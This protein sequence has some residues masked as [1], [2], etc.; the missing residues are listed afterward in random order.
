MPNH[1]QKGLSGII[2]ILPLFRARRDQAHPVYP[3]QEDYS[4]GST[5]TCRAH[6]FASAVLSMRES[7]IIRAD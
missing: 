5:E 3:L 7:G 6:Q 4:R 1:W 2:A